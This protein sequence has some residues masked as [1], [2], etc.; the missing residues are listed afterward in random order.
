MVRNAGVK[1]NYK[2]MALYWSAN[3]NDGLGL[4]GPVLKLCMSELCLPFSKSNTVL[5]CISHSF[6]ILLHFASNQYAMSTNQLYA[7]QNSMLYR[8]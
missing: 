5:H 3:G 2:I 8:L 6:N 1:G 4:L 7:L